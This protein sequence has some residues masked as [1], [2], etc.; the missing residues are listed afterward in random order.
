MKNERSIRYYSQLLTRVSNSN[1]FGGITKKNSNYFS[2]SS[3]Y[4]K[5]LSVI[6]EKEMNLEQKS[7][8]WTPLHWAV[9][10]GIL[11]I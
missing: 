9:N 2:F 8:E 3:G 7:R 4:D 5:L 10:E 11:N 1:I 6:I